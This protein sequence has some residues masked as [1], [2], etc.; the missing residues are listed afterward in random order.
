LREAGSAARQAKVR[1]QLIVGAESDGCVNDPCVMF[2]MRVPPRA[3][4]IRSGAYENHIWKMELQGRPN[5]ET[6]TEKL[7]ALFH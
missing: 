3:K 2:I 5:L 1:L 6:F 4:A 7:T